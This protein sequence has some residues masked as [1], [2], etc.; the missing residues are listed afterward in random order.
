MNWIIWLKPKKLCVKYNKSQKPNINKHRSKSK[1]WVEKTNIFPFTSK[2]SAYCSLRNSGY[3]WDFFPSCSHGFISHFKC[4]II[5]VL[6]L[7]KFCLS[8][9]SETEFKKKKNFQKWFQLIVNFF[10]L[11]HKYWMGSIERKM[12]ESCF[13]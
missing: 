13:L 5:M 10:R 6:S 11:K 8:T 3:K 12:H 4:I 7:A 1:R 9:Y 2:I